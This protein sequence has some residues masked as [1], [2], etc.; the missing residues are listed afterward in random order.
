MCF[1]ERSGFG[2]NALLGRAPPITP[3]THSPADGGSANTAPEASEGETLE[4]LY[5]RIGHFIEQ[6]Q[7]LDRLAQRYGPRFAPPKLLR[8]MA[9]KGETFYGGVSAKQA[10]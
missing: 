6:L 7:E 8:D 2:L 3:R 9:A 5:P 1:A 10:A 4:A